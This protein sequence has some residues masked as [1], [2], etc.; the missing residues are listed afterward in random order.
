MAATGSNLRSTANRQRRRRY[1]ASALLSCVL[2]ATTGCFSAKVGIKVTSDGAGEVSVDFF[3]SKELL[4]FLGGDLRAIAKQLRESAGT[5]AS[6]TLVESITD[7]RGEGL[8]VE[9]PLSRY[10][11]IETDVSAGKGESLSG[12][13]L[14]GTI[15]FLDIKESKGVWT[16]AADLD[17][18]KLTGGL[19]GLPTAGLPKIFDEPEIAFTASLPGRVSRS[20]ADSTSWGTA[21]WALDTAADG[22]IHLEMTNVP[23]PVVPIAL[24]SG[25]AVISVISLA[26]AIKKLRRRRA[27]ASLEIE[28]LDA[29]SSGAA[30]AGLGIDPGADSA[31]IWAPKRPAAPGLTSALPAEPSRPETT[32]PPADSPPPGWYKDPAGSDGLR[33]WD[34]TT[35]TNHL[36]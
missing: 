4:A 3:P 11:I 20:N 18:A 25:L 6:G 24:A 32:P 9:I 33:W 26:V 15:Q 19:F 31:D 30:A 8:R 13:L 17:L 35:W 34:G 5:Q 10:Q 14:G 16:F 22:V 36:A 28:L 12:S 21:T 29:R 27:V 7:G 2:L 23:L 1:A